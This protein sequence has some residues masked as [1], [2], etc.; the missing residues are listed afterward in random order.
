LVVRLAISMF[1]LLRGFGKAVKGTG[2]AAEILA[3]SVPSK[4]AFMYWLKQH[5]RV[6][7]ALIIRETAAR[8]GNKPGGYIWAILDPLAHVLLMSFLFKAIARA[9]AIGTDFALFFASGYLPFAAYQGMTAFMA[10]AVKANKNLFSY[11]VVA[12]IDAV[13]ARYILQLLTSVLVTI[14]IFAVCTSEP[15]HFGSINLGNAVEA[16]MLATL[17]GLGVGMANI[18]LFN[19]FPIYEKIFGLI[20]RPMFLISGVF[21][22]P[23]ALPRQAHEFLMWNP[24]VH[25]IMWFRTGIFP[26]YKANGLD[27]GYVI[28]WAFFSIVIGFTLFTMS[29]SLREDRI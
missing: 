14:I 28:G 25:I 11:P 29:R 8:Y 17:L 21:H 6:S 15:E 22:L 12:P 7:A 19:D 23:D 2:P 4:G 10:G 16:F 5:L 20:N 13:V 1:L 18:A 26:G 9:P 27:V 24:L 3:D